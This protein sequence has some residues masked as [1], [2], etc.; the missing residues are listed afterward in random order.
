M[1][2]VKM[3]SS[4]LQAVHSSATPEHGTPPDVVEASR[5]VLG[6]ID[7]DPASSKVFNEIVRADRYF[8][9]E[10]DGLA[11]EWGNPNGINVF[12]NSPSGEKGNLAKRFWERL[13]D[14]YLRDMVESAIY[15]GFSI[16]QLQTL[17]NT[18]HGGPMKL[19]I[20]IPRKRLQFSSMIE[21]SSQVGLFGDVE[22]DV[23]AT[24]G[25][26]PTKPNFICLLPSR[27]GFGAVGEIQKERF[28]DEFSK[29]GEVRV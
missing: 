15:I 25:S 11:Q 10:D 28:N 5:R 4:I 3:K 27:L 26:S 19:P 1:I 21:K 2:E 22:P 29:F 20:C 24:K 18:K 14:E 13:T 7:L 6:R 9:K 8:T 17:Q 23:I 12:L 16:D